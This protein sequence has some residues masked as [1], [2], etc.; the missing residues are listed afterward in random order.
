MDICIYFLATF[1]DVCV[2]FPWQSV[3]SAE[4][5]RRPFSYRRCCTSPPPNLLL[6]F[7]RLRRNIPH[8]L[9]LGCSL[10]Q[11][12][13]QCY[14]S[15]KRWWSLMM[16]QFENSMEQNLNRLLMTKSLMRRRRKWV[17]PRGAH[18]RKVLR[19]VQFPGDGLRLARFATVPTNSLN[20]VVS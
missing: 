7:R 8:S 13:P 14:C 2:S 17:K 12:L 15:P 1:S 3:A 20:R 10:Q 5:K 16:R 6:S 19:V 11:R 4:K 9:L 18:E